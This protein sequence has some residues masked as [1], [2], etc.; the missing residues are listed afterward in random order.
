MRNLTPDQE[1]AIL[2]RINHKAD[3]R[4]TLQAILYFT[5]LTV[6]TVLIY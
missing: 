2:D 4:A 5:I 3:T 6:I 1:Q